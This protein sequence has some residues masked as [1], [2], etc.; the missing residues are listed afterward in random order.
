LASSTSTDRISYGSWNDAVD[1]LGDDARPRHGK[2]EAFAPHVLEQDRQVQLAAARHQERV[3]VAGLLD[4][5]RH[6]GQELAHQAVAQ[7]PRRHVLAFAAGERRRVHLE[8]HRQRRLVH[9]DRRQ[10]VRRVDGRQRR[11]DRQVVDAGDEDDVAGAGLVDRHPLHSGEHEHLADFRLDGSCAVGQRAVQHRD[12]LPGPERPAADAAD[13]QPSDIVRIVECAY[14]ELQRRG[15]VT[16]R[17]RHAREDRLEQRPHRRA[18]GGNAG[19]RI[20]DVERRP[21]VQ[22]RRVDDRKVE[23]LIVGPQPVEQLERL[24]DDPLG[25]RSR[26]VDLVDDDD[27]LQ[28]E[29]Q[30]LERDEPRLRHGPLHRIDQQQ[31]AVDHAE[32]ALDLAAEVRMTRRIDDIDMGIAELDRAV[33]GKDRDP[34]LALEVIAVH[35]P[36]ADVLVLGERARLHQQLVDERRLAVVDV[37]DDRDVPELAG[38][39]HCGLDCCSAEKPMIIAAPGDEAPQI[40]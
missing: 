35:H 37:G 25:A 17:Y 36:F 34:P 33:L 1:F 9:R 32:H 12:L 28:A 5:Q 6:V 30:R 3:G 20:L 39:G 4:A 22:R 27:R 15:D 26:T 10:R 23:L 40:F 31:H 29:L 18:V 24:V 38:G 13:A 21:A 8:V 11:A 16:H 19:L 2:L 7:V 14:L